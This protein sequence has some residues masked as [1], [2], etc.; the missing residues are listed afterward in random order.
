VLAAVGR[1]AV[2]GWRESDEIPAASRR[3]RTAWE[4]VS[5]TLWLIWCPVFA[6]LTLYNWM[7]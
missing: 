1:G 6:I 3:I 7:V 5:R 2:G 4:L